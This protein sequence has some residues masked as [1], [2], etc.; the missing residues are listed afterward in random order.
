MDS[1]S[2]QEL[3]FERESVGNFTLQDM[4]DLDNAGFA[5]AILELE[6]GMFKNKPWLIT[7]FVKQR[8]KAKRT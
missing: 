1:I 5:R 4:I 6:S 2:F 7:F 8:Q 3:L